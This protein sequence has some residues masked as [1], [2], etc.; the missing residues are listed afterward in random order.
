MDEMPCNHDYL[1]PNTT[2]VVSPYRKETWC[3]GCGRK[4]DLLPLNEATRAMAL[5]AREHM[6]FGGSTHGKN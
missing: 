2:L 3:V 4:R 5:A 1:D 6:L